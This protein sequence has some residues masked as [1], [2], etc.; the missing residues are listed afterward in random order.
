MGTAEWDN[1]LSVYIA[2]CTSKAA[3]S[4]TRNKLLFFHISKY[5]LESFSLRTAFSLRVFETLDIN[6]RV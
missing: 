6:L 4:T 5:C 1:L 3:K 2:P